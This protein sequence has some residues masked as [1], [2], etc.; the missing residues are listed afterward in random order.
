MLREQLGPKEPK[1][2]NRTLVAVAVMLGAAMLGLRW[3]G[4]WNPKRGMGLAF[5][6]LAALL[7]VLGMLYS[8][9]PL[10]RLTSARAWMQAH[11]YLGW[12][13]LV[14]VI[15]HAGWTWPHGWMGFMLLGLSVWVSF[16]GSAS[17]CRS[18]CPPR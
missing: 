1:N 6:I 4:S 7:L 13:A 10:R 15:L 5:G 17:S 2:L 8:S 3:S 12:L 14:A 16:S 9:R 18:A 11:V